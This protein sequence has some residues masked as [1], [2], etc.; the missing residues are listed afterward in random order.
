MGSSAYY[1][2]PT[3]AQQPFKF[4][5]PT[6]PLSQVQGGMSRNHHNA[7]EGSWAGNRIVERRREEG[8]GER[9]KDEHVMSWA[10]YDGGEGE[11]VS[12]SA[13]GGKGKGKE[14]AGYRL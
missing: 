10:V 1:P 5:G 12:A 8:G 11:N 7:Q 13:K 2:T 14:V 9:R 4:N 3:Q 6:S